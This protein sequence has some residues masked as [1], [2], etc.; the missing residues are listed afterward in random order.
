[1][2]VCQTLL[3]EKL[4]SIIHTG[5][6]SG[7]ENY[8]TWKLLGPLWILGK[9]AG[10]GQPDFLSPGHFS[11][12][13]YRFSPWHTATFS[14]HRKPVE[15]D[16]CCWMFNTLVA[17]QCVFRSHITDVHL[18]HKFCWFL[19]PILHTVLN[20]TRIQ[21]V[22]LVAAVRML[23]GW[24]HWRSNVQRRPLISA[25]KVSKPGFSS[26]LTKL[27]AAQPLPVAKCPATH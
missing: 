20:R 24:F 21:T 9:V 10:Q 17:V 25:Y 4:V 15:A 26:I 23:P 5:F 13:F 11:S 2:V 8:F 14:Y 6:H 18:R 3:L 16:E 1:M 12:F 27:P 22:S 7:L 19:F